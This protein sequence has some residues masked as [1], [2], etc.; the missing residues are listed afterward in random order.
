V[1][2]LTGLEPDKYLFI[3]HFSTVFAVFCTTSRTDV[4]RRQ[5]LARH[6]Q[7]LITNQNQALVYALV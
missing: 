6:S 2:R 5:A 3:L 1:A 7:C 4:R